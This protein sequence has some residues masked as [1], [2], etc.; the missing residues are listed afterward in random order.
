MSGV[1]L[2]GGVIVT[3]VGLLVYDMLQGLINEEV[4]VR[5]GRLPFTI[6]RLAARQLPEELRQEIYENEWVADLRFL[7]SEDAESG[8]I[9][10]LVTAN[11]FA[12]SLL[13]RRGGAR[14][15][16]ELYA[17]TAP[18]MREFT[19]IRHLPRNRRRRFHALTARLRELSALPVGNLDDGALAR[20][21]AGIAIAC[22]ALVDDRAE[23]P[24]AALAA[25]LLSASHPLAWRLGLDHPAM[26][27][28]RR[29][30]AHARLQMGH[31]VAE[32]LLRELRRDEA[33]LFGREDPRTFRTRHLL[34]WAAAMAGRLAEAEAG[35]LDLEARMARLADPDL[36]LLRHIQCK[37]S[38]VQ[39]L[40][41]KV[42]E[43]VEG[44]DRVTADRSR[45]L[46]AR[47]VD[48]L[49]TRHSEGKMFVLGGHAVRGRDI[50]R[51]V[52][53]ERRRLRG[54]GH[55]D[56]L[57]TAKYLAVARF[58]AGPPRGAVA[59]RLLRARLQRILTAQIRSRGADHPD[60]R[61]TLRLLAKYTT[62]EETS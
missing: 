20:L 47:H 21:A 17:H 8:P 50:L 4:R 16:K 42:R 6:L 27:D 61:D 7:L 58:S 46:G 19:D 31:A 33:R 10:R 52:L 37:R 11:R 30:H 15:A 29:A 14:T 41:G 3:F 39:G 36:P 9:T 51:P 2:A 23:R 49:D 22:Q 5:L 56:T 1:L 26:L 48:T 38:W 57:E 18:S 45:E 40:L 60:T 24:A 13:L 44:Y 55:P 34:W 28:L 53:R 62:R 59:R 35:L 54:R 25:P 32:G 43:A 12:L